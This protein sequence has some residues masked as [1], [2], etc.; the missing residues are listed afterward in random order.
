M[1]LFN[2]ELD[3]TAEEFYDKYSLYA[4]IP[5]S[6]WVDK[7]KMNEEE[8]KTVKGWETMGGYLKTLEYKEACQ[9][10][11]NENTD[12]HERFLSLPGFDSEIFKEITGIDVEKPDFNKLAQPTEG[13]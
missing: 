13:E 8:K 9:V 10:W 11:W 7:E 1:R 6:R 2:K 4:D 12:E 5:L 3:M